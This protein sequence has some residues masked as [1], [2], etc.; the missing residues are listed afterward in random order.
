[1]ISRSASIWLFRCRRCFA[2]GDFE[3]HVS[4]SMTRVSGALSVSVMWNLTFICGF[5]FWHG[6][7]TPCA[8]Q[9][10]PLRRAGGGS[11]QEG[12]VRPAARRARTR[13]LLTAMGTQ[14]P[15]LLVSTASSIDW[16]LF[17]CVIAVCRHV[18]PLWKPCVFV[19]RFVPRCRCWNGRP[20]L[21]LSRMMRGLNLL[22]IL[23]D[24]F[25]FTPLPSVGWA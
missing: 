7:E 24:Q 17:W 12:V 14:S 9:T 16:R 4:S 22:T 19:A 20:F 21:V 23:H 8:L 10:L 2:C 18:L 5:S 25:L 15:I 13:S 6:F 11:G 1:M 3:L